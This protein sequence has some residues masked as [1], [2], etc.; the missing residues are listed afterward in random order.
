M[1]FYQWYFRCFHYLFE[2]K[3]KHSDL[4]F[5]LKASYL[6]VY[7]EKVHVCLI[8]GKW[9]VKLVVV[10]QVSMSA[11]PQPII[12]KYEGQVVLENNNKK[13]LW[14]NYTTY[15]YQNQCRYKDS[16]THLHE[17]EFC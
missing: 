11:D 15:L 14:L 13:I 8:L 6:E 7:I 4:E 2:L 5:T 12:L 17:E 1:L 10:N 3:E 16:L 9:L